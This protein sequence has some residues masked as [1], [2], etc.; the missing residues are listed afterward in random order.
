M[1]RNFEEMRRDLLRFMMSERV[2][3][4]GAGAL[5]CLELGISRLLSSQNV[6]G[7]EDGVAEERERRERDLIAFDEGD[8]I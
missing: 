4:R 2:K 5:V 6:G 8:E 1:W 7:E 3:E